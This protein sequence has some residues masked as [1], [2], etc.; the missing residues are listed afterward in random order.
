MGLVNKGTDEDKSIKLTIYT[1]VIDEDDKV[2]SYD[3]KGT[4]LEV[5]YKS[6][7]SKPVNAICGGVAF[8][9]FGLHFGCTPG[10]YGDK[11]QLPSNILP[12]LKAK[13]FGFHILTFDGEKVDQIS[14][15]R[16]AAPEY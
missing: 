4:T 15:R 10:T 9:R 11:V 1:P 6:A 14:Y 2:V 12:A 13:I 5:A 16:T 3:R 8:L 7:E